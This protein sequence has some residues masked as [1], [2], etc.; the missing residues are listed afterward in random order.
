VIGSIPPAPALRQARNIP[1]RGLTDEQTAHR[2]QKPVPAGDVD[3]A[4]SSPAGGGRLDSIDLLRGLVMVIMALDHVRGFFSNAIGINPTDLNQ[5]NPALFLTRW[6]THYCAPTFVFL[7]GTSAFLYGRRCQTRGQLAWFLLTRGIWLVIL[8]VTL[9]RL[10]WSFNLDYRFGFGGGVIWAIGCSMIA[11]AG[12]VFLPTSAVAVVGVALIAFHNLWDIKT[13]ADVGLPE[14]LWV[15][16]HRG[17]DFP[18]LPEIFKQLR[19]WI[20][21]LPPWVVDLRFGTGYC[22]LPWIGVIAAGYGFGAIF[23]L[24]PAERRRQLL[25][26]GLALTALFIALRYTNYYGD[27]N[28]RTDSWPGPWRVHDDWWFTLF[29][30]VNCQKYPPSLLFALMTLG[31]TITLLGL[32]EGGTGRLGRALVVFGRVP[33]FYYLLHIPLIHALAI[34]VDYARY[35]SSPLWAKGPWDLHKDLLPGVAS[36]VGLTGTPMASGPLLA[37]STLYPGSIH[38]DSVPPDYGLS[39]PGVYL[40]WACV[41][42]LLWPL[43]WWY[44]GVKRR[45]RSGWLSYL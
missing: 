27:P 45:H 4:I 32:F 16:L 33:L 25:G 26:L 35:G 36:T 20:P 1:M 17:G 18:F 40:A 6:I 10:G 43:C 37:G 42:L 5:T 7:A 22:L 2:V 3:G 44:A 8:E 15:S 24:N 30:F 31:P 38:L 14:W 39:L 11:L 28:S 12:L 34:G 13:A 41:I 29:S 21:A 9:V 23:L 19:T